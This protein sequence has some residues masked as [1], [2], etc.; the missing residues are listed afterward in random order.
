MRGAHHAPW[1]FLLVCL[2]AAW[3]CCEGVAAASH[4]GVGCNSNSEFLTV[5]DTAGSQ[6][7][8]CYRRT[9]DKENGPLYI[10][11]NTD[12]GA[13]G[14]GTGRATAMW[15]FDVSG[16]DVCSQSRRPPLLSPVSAIVLLLD[17]LFGVAGVWA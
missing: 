2:L 9:E 1:T 15:P 17:W 3:S 13:V 5:A 16:E 12:D 11:I 8:G 7:A 10:N 14:G 4:A 6:L